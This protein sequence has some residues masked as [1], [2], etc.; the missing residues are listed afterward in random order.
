MTELLFIRHGYSE[1]NK[2][3][4]FSGQKDF[5][6][7]EAGR[8]QAEELKSYLPKAYH[9]DAFYSSDLCRAVD[10]VKP[11]ADALSLPVHT[12]AA[13]R[14]VDVGLW[15]GVLREDVER[16]Y[17]ETYAL[18][19]NRPG[20]VR[21]DGGESFAEMRERA[22][23][24]VREIV[25]RHEGE[26]VAIA[27]HG[28]VIRALRTLWEDIPLERMEEIPQ[29]PNASVTVVRYEGE[30]ASLLLIGSCDHLT[31]RVTERLVN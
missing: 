23:L 16:L 29:V 21:F 9:I 10:T 17:P 4:R 27:T 26:T 20:L 13:L 8:R 5:P 19:R 28:G 6:L 1:G 22:L 25:A 7:D 30:T 15:E 18:Y 3:H 14:E 12:T 11:S 24:A 2:S 31:E